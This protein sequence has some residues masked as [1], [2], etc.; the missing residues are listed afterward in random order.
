MFFISDGEKEKKY[1]Y[2]P[3]TVHT[4]NLVANHSFVVG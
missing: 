3:A 2:I 1:R 4:I